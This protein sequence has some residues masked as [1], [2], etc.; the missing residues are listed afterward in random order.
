MI[1]R[2]T[3]LKELARGERVE[4]KGRRPKTTL[5]ETL[6]S[7][8][9]KKTKCQRSTRTRTELC[10]RRCGKTGCSQEMKDQL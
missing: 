8:C 5:W 4:E 1:T 2:N 7:G 10:P 9:G 6:E 3:R